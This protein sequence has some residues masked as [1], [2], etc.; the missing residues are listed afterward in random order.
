VAK[1]L[2]LCLEKKTCES[3]VF[4][5]ADYLMHYGIKGMHW[6]VRRT[7]EQLGH[8]KTPKQLSNDLKAIKYKN[9]TNLMSPED[10]KKSKKGSCHDQVMFEMSELRKI[11]IRPKAT[12]VMEC[13]DDGQ[14]GMTHSFVH[15][16][17]GSNIVWLENAW[18]DKAGIHKYKSLNAI[19]REIRSAHKSGRFG[20][21]KKYKNLV[22]GEFDDTKHKPGES[23]Q[24][25]VNKCVRS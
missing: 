19:K 12:F 17:D 9:F 18:K 10:V 14:G 25:L 1:G 23:L 11:G 4:I 3:G 16:K 20:N 7:P 15:Y 13:S 8:I 6:G 2:R 22:F 21:S 24:E 5:M